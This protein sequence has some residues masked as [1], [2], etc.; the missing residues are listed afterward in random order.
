MSEISEVEQINPTNESETSLETARLSEMW[1]KFLPK[2][3]NAEP[4]TI[5]DQDIE[6]VFTKN[7]TDDELKLNLMLGAIKMS[8]KI[9]AIELSEMAWKKFGVTTDPALYKTLVGDPSPDL[10]SPD[11]KCSVYVD[12][13]GRLLAVGKTHAA[14]ADIYGIPEDLWSGY[15]WHLA[16]EDFQRRTGAIQGGVY[17]V[18]RMYLVPSDQ[19]I[20][21]AQLLTLEKLFG[22]LE[23]VGIEA[24]GFP[25]K[26]FEESP[27][28]SELKEYIEASKIRSETIN[29][30]NKVS[31]S[32]T[33]K[34]TFYSIEHGKGFLVQS[35]WQSAYDSAKKA[36]LSVVDSTIAADKTVK[37]LKKTGY[38]TGH[39]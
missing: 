10:Q 26:E 4:H 33:D 9:P 38:F 18:N 39:D 35:G 29:D 15:Y 21:Q 13:K 32:D 1:C 11:F 20:T 6:H 12:T 7:G 2:Y 30:S 17:D 19:P 28:A 27:T 8:Q 3:K 24:E 37:I 23:N 36:G 22:G 5:T 25:P 34:K 31:Y 16:S 14:I